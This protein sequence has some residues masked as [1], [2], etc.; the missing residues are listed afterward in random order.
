MTPAMESGLWTAAEAMAATNGRT[1]AEWR[2]EGVSIDSRM[3][4]PGDL[5][6]AI[7]GPKFDG[8]D[9]AADALAAD[10]A[11]AV[12][13]RR[14]DGIEDDAPLLIVNE[15]TIALEDLGRAARSR[16]NAK[17]IAVTGSVGKTG[18]KEALRFVL[19]KQGRCMASEGS[20][21]NHWGVPLSLSRMP[22]D[23]DFGIF[24]IGMNHAG[25]ITPLTEMVSP[26]V[27]V[28]TNVEAVH[29]AHFDSIEAIADAKAEIFQGLG[30]DGA[31]VINRDSV[32]YDHLHAAAIAAN[33]NNVI[34]FGGHPEARVRVTEVSIESDGSTIRA[35][36][37]GEEILYRLGL[38]GRHWV[39]NSLAVLAAVHAAGGDVPEAA[40][41]LSAIHGLKGRGLQHTVAME[42]GSFVVI[43]ESYNASPVSMRAAL[44]ILGQL[45]PEGNGRRI[46]VLGD[47]LELG[48]QSEAAHAELAET[49]IAEKIDLVFTAGQYMAALWEALAEPMR[50][51]NAISAA[52]VLAQVT[53]AIRPGDVVVVKGSAGSKT[54]PIV[55]ALLEMGAGPQ[56]HEHAVNG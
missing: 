3:V 27:A 31:A 34:G 41:A 32:L 49:L 36:V 14:P 1:D 10:A 51:G 19:E 40:A 24:E 16:T 48:E 37:D 52:E 26:H 45:Q 9:F 22:A 46:A 29:S 8:H 53:D 15:T 55:D 47:M 23:T 6:V 25:E 4:N 17:I 18:T 30:S 20:F 39:M 43:D 12:V 56:T 28:I 50:G 38:P 11:A 42:G 54:G 44:E 13:D 21:N 7:R 33:I 35:L 2:A 5:F